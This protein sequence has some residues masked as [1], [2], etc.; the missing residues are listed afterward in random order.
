[1]IA[2]IHISDMSRRGVLASLLRTPAPKSTPGLHYAVKVVGAPLTGSVM[3]APSFKR[4]ALF[5]MWDSDEAL[6]AFVADNPKA[7]LSTGWHSRLD[8]V[9]V[10]DYQ[11]SRGLKADGSWPPGIPTALAPA[12]DAEGPVAVLT[13][14]RTRMSQLPRF[15][16]SSAR[17]AKP[18]HSS[19]G[20]IWAT[21]LVRPPVVA[22]FSLWESAAAAHAYACGAGGAHQSAIDADRAKAF[23]KK[24]AFFRFTPNESAGHLDGPNPLPAGCLSLPSPPVELHTVEEPQA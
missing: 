23:H 21:A 11:A 18:L 13:F 10:L 4:V 5:A 16:R 24:G 22:T 7:A 14:A 19:P 20:L 3:T 8:L 15:L 2:S 1:L 6:E 17:A 12:A 9:H